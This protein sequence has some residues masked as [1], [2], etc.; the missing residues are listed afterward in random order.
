M[1]FFGNVTQVP[2][3]KSGTPFFGNVTQVVRVGRRFFAML[4]RLSER[5]AVFWQ[6]YAGARL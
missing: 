1:P 5:D 2:G 3:C 4:P 6:C